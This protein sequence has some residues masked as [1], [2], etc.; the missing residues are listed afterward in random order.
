MDKLESLPWWKWAKKT[1]QR[2][3][4]ISDAMKEVEDEIAARRKFLEM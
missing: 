2:R 4:D 3:D 1:E